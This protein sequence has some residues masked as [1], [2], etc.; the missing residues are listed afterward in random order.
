MNVDDPI[1]TAYALGELSKEEGARVAADVAESPE[2]QRYVS[3]I[4][5]FSEVLKAGYRSEQENEAVHR[6]N[7]IDIR[8]DRWFWS[9]ARPLSIA[10]VIAVAALIAGVIVSSKYR[11][12]TRFESARVTMGAGERLHLPPAANTPTLD[13]QGEFVAGD[14]QAK[15]AATPPSANP[16]FEAGVR[17]RSLEAGLKTDKII[18]GKGSFSGG[19]TRA[20]E[21]GDPAA[22]LHRGDGAVPATTGYLS[23]TMQFAIFRRPARVLTRRLPHGRPEHHARRTTQQHIDAGASGAGRPRPG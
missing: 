1:L 3:E 9:I 11:G 12:E 20:E 10:A 23:W 17:Y 8:G 7:L 18:A 14:P 2:A 15:A 16:G 13:V 6:A 21:F 4:Q 5:E 22:T 19:L